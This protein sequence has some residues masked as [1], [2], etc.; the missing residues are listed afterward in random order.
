MVLVI[1]LVMV[2]SILFLM[3]VSF[4]LVWG[5]RCSWWWL[6]DS[7]LVLV[8]MCSSRLFRLI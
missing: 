5:L 8:V 1:R 3:L 6:V 7:V 2:L 4:M